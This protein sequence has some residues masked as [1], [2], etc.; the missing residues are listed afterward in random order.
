MKLPLLYSL[1]NSL[2][3]DDKFVAFLRLVARLGG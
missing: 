2:H 1:I 3:V